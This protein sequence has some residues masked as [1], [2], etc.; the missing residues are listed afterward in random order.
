VS[1][2]SATVQKYLPTTML[3]GVAVIDYDSDGLLDLF[4]VNGAHVPDPM[5][6]G[7]LP[8]KMNPKY[9]DRLYRNEGN[10]RFVDVT[11]EAGLRGS[12]YGQGAAVGDYDNDGDADLY[13]TGIFRNALYRNE[14]DGS[15][16]EVTGQAGVASQGWSTSAAFLDYDA[17]GWLDLVVARYVR[18]SFEAN[19]YC[20]DPS[21]GRRSYC[22]PDEFEPLSPL[23]YRNR[24]D[25]TFIDV[26]RETGLADVPGKG[27]GVALND[28][29]G[30]GRLDI[31]LANDSWPQHLF[32]NKP[33]NHFEEQGLLL[34]VA[35][36]EDGREFAGMGTDFQDYDNDGRPDLFVNALA[37]QSYHL[38]RNEGD[39]F[40]HVSIATGV[41]EATQ[42]SS[43]WGAAFLDFDN[44]GWKD[45]F[46]AQG[47]VMDDIEITQ[48]G[49]RYREPL[50]MLRNERATFRD[51]SGRLGAAFQQPLAARGSAV[52]DLNNDG[53]LD[54]VVYRNQ[55]SPLILR[56]E[57]VAN[58]HWLLVSIKGAE[59][60]RDGIGAQL[61]LVAEDGSQQFVTVSAAGS[62]L[63]A[64]DRRAHFGLGANQRIKLLEIRWPSGRRQRLE[65]IAADQILEVREPS[66]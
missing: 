63:S 46:V 53:F 19:P 43:G 38:Y 25:G 64:R 23:L 20:G 35:Y 10:G 13:V 32:R 30:D 14:G 6:G 40:Q 7:E 61:R 8:D 26:S 31:F 27:L 1:A 52:A 5:P 60:N 15:F 29:D 37:R 21:I 45:I 17:D 59:S 51:V 47:H 3:G 12:F 50:L 34:G 28:F 39:A 36:D 57:G 65:D 4:F 9:W 56:N 42:L 62:Y 55:G 24:G 41:S 16:R 54:L 22:H 44:D 58:A 48:P 66:K 11:E 18:W 49:L 2:P 33:G